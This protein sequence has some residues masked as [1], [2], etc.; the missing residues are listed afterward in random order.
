M[1][2]ATWIT[3]VIAGSLIAISPG[4]GAV[5]SM[6]HGLAYG[7]R[8]AS[9]TVLGLQ[10]GL[11][12]IFVIAGVGV[13]SLLM[14]SELAFNIVKTV[15]ALYLI[16]CG[17][18]QWRAMPQSAAPDAAPVA[19]CPS[20]GRRMLT[21]FLTNATNPKGIIFMVAVLPS[22]IS[23]QAPLLPQL[24][25][26]GATMVAIDCVVMHGYAWL[27]SAMQR[28]FRDAR[29]VKKQNR[30]FGGVLVLVGAALF[31]VKRSPG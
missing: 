21:G 10:I 14:A 8:K 28:Y 24:L 11:L 22:F 17:V 23:Q 15:G 7:L 4:S 1:T 9:A 31:F 25:I 30:F 6:S 27:A 19:A 3:F 26:L 20:F 13:G 2:L 18:S 5:M 16:Y 12:L 29:A